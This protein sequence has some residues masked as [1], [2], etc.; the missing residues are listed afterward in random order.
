MKILLIDNH[1][2]LLPQLKRALSDHD[3]E[4][5]KYQPGVKLSASG[6]DLV[7]LSGG[8]GRGREMRDLHINGDLWYR[9]EL[10]FIMKCQK[11]ILGICMGF[12]IIAYAY[13]SKLQKLPRRISGFRRIQT[14]EGTYIKQFKY[15]DWCI[16][17]VSDEHFEIL[18]RS[19]IGVEMIRHKK[20]PILAIQFHP[21][22]DGG[23]LVLGHLIKDLEVFSIAH[24]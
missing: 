2:K 4:I 14:A 12:Q 21:E 22:M 1:T 24:P 23:S 17:E 15:H 5:V 6:Q 13:G 11:P 8:G 7:I 19:K 20:R 3:V 18:G 10:D 9:D 16:P